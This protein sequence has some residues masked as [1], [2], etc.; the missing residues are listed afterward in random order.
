MC[1]C[2][3]FATNNDCFDRQRKFILP[4]LRYMQISDSVKG[5][6]YVHINWLKDLYESVSVRVWFF[7]QYFRSIRELNL[8]FKFR[9]SQFF[10]LY[11]SVVCFA[12]VI[13]IHKN[14]CLLFMIYSVGLAWNYSNIIMITC[15][16]FCMSYICCNVVGLGNLICSEW[17]IVFICVGTTLT[18]NIYIHS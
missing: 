11:L 2:N 13:S 6:Y 10:S 14:A 1:G 4:L 7:L 3:L 18:R 5:N 9:L 12:T 15:V 16:I 8:I 17:I